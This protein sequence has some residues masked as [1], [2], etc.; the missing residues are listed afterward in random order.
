MDNSQSTLLQGW[1]GITQHQRAQPDA[2]GLGC[3]GTPFGSGGAVPDK[4]IDNYSYKLI[5]GINYS[6]DKL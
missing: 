2:H 5:V 4:S 6:W 3:F 1:R